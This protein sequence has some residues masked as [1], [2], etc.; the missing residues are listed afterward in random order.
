MLV[1]EAADRPGSGGCR[2][3]VA[4]VDSDSLTI[5]CYLVLLVILSSLLS[6]NVVYA[7]GVVG[8]V[9]LFWSLGMGE[10][11]SPTPSRAR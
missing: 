8:N 7:A 10:V 11:V 5:L 6:G 1:T 3:V 2:Y 4:L 9:S